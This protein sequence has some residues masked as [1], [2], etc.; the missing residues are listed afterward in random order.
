M[1]IGSYEPMTR[2]S[3]VSAS[4]TSRASARKVNPM[5]DSN[6]T[7]VTPAPQ[8][9]PVS[10]YIF[11]AHDQ[12]AMVLGTPASYP[13]DRKRHIREA[14]RELWRALEALEQAA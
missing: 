3:P 2:Q 1:F 11:A 8:P 7:T 6:S 12:L 14:L 5:R 10:A 4:D 13:A 9:Q